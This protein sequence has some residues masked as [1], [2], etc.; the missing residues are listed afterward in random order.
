MMVLKPMQRISHEGSG[1]G[2]LRRPR[3]SSRSPRMAPGEG[4]ASGFSETLRLGREPEKP[5]ATGLSETLRPGWDLEK[6]D[7]P[8]VSEALP[9]GD[10]LSWASRKELGKGYS[11][12]LLRASPAS[13]R[14]PEMGD[15]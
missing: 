1:L 12:G 14:E 2:G 9:M 11:W 10:S 6:G 7:T 13:G 15:S 4:D 8:E 5:D 3:D